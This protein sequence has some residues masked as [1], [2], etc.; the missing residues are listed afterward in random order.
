MNAA[1]V[2]EN[3]VRECLRNV[4]DPEIG[5]SLT[6]LDMVGEVVTRDGNGVAVT[7]QLPTPAYPRRERIAQSIEAVIAAKL[8]EAGRVDVRFTARV[9]G[10]RSGGAIGLSVQNVIAVG[11]GKGGVGKS[12]VAAALAVGLQLSGAK[13]GLMDADIYGPSIPHLFGANSR[14]EIVEEHGAGGQAVRRIQPIDAGGVKLMS[15]GF[16]V[17]TDEPVIVRGPIL[18]RTIQQFLQETAWGELDYLIIDLPPGTGDIALT[19]SQLIGLA[20]AVVVCTPQQLALL[21][22]VK[23]IN[24]FRKV[25]IPVLG[26]VENMTGAIFGRGGAKQKAAEMGVRFLG[27][28][29]IDARIRVQ[30][31]AGQIREL[32]AEGSESRPYLFNVC[33]QTAVEIARTLLET[34]TMP[35]LE[36]L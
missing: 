27:E 16:L 21:D 28:I 25:K 9:K 12:T 1:K 7:V 6:D 33:E 5:R 35:T 2:T 31:D 19:L 20:G 36:I 32:F 22:A 29:P 23:A 30:G 11:S 26:V 13:V 17:G 8:P 14:P 15:I 3:Q 10:K 18:H 24:M 4:N 34:P